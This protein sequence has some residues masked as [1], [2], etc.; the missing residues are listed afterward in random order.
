MNIHK[1]WDAQIISEP[2][3]ELITDLI[4]FVNIINSVNIINLLL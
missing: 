4:N 1:V 3:I 2:E